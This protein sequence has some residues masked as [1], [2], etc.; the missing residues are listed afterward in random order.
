MY[1]DE[2][3]TKQ[4]QRENQAPHTNAYAY[5]FKAFVEY[6]NDRRVKD[7][8]KAGLV[9]FV[10][11]I[12]RPKKGRSN[13]TIHDH[14]RAAKA[15]FE[16]ARTRMDDD[17][18]P[19]GLYNWFRVLDRERRKRPYKLPRHNRAPMRPDVFRKQLPQADEQA[20]LD[21]DAYTAALPVPRTPGRG[22]PAHLLG[23]DVP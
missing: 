16:A 1:I 9:R 18:F 14:L 3:R 12:L 13:K 6:L 20:K 17:V 5:R 19:E 10:D 15:D 11:R 21:I 4:Q 7:L 2:F 23:S 8:K 22:K